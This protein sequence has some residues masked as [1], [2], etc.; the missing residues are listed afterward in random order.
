M[1][2]RTVSEQ[3][4]MDLDGNRMSGMKQR[5]AHT[6]RHEQKSGDCVN[7]VNHTVGDGFSH[8]KEICIN[9][10]WVSREA[11]AI[12]KLLDPSLMGES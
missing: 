3:N 6:E 2:Q 8:E 10:G 4:F 12:E 7:R 11:R 9:R 1:L 5:H